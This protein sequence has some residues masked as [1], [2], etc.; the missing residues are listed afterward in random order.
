MAFTEVYG[1]GFRPYEYLPKP[2]N[3]TNSAVNQTLQSGMYGLRSFLFP[4]VFALVLYTAKWTCLD[5]NP[6]MVK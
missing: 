6:Y 1:Y 2:V 4:D 5:K 3:I